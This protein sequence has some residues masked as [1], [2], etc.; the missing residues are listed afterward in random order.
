MEEKKK[1]HIIDTRNEDEVKQPYASED[2]DKKTW[3]VDGG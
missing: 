2:E 3:E 1:N